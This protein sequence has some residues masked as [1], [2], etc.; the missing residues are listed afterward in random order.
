MY[1]YIRVRIKDHNNSPHGKFHRYLLPFSRKLP[2]L[3]FTSYHGSLYLPILCHV[4]HTVS[5]GY[6][7]FKPGRNAKWNRQFPEFPNFQK[8]GQ[9]REVN[10]NFWNEFPESFCSIRFWTGISRNF[11]R[12]ERALTFSLLFSSLSFLQK[13][14]AIHACI[15]NM[16]FSWIMLF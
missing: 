10:R 13:M 6:L 4:S 3:N 9:P 1:V 12:M 14:F 8:K 15:N 7:L 16:V 5:L 11:G 2:D